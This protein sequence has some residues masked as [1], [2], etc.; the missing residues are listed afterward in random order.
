MALLKTT[1]SSCSANAKVDIPE[2]MID[3]EVEQMNQEQSQQ[4]RYQG[5]E[6]DQYLGYIGQT[7]DAFRR[8]AS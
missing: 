8:T 7:M 2:A 5:I 1:L 6:L 3:R 4:M